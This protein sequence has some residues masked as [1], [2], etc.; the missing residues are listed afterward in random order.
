MH[1][2]PILIELGA[3]L[4]LLAGIA[5]LAHRVGLSPV[6]LYLL[7]GLAFGTGGLVPVELSG[8]F[9]ELSAE[10]GVLLLL[11]LLGAEY[12]GR[13]LVDGLRATAPVA[14][15]DA[16]VNIGI[17]VAAG[18][19]LG[20]TPAGALV[21]GGIT[22]ASSSGIVAKLVD[23][24][25]WYGNREVP[26]I[27]AL[28]VAED[29]LMALYLPVL[30]VLLAGQVGGAPLRITLAVAVVVVVLVLAARYGPPVSDRFAHRSPEVVLLGALGLMLLVAGLVELVDV[31]A[32][33][34][35]FLVGIAIS[36]AF[37]DA[38]K[39]LLAPLRDLFAALFFVVFGLTID[40]A[41][42]TPVLPVALGLAVV[43]G[44]SKYG[45]GIALA[46]REGLGPAATRRTGTILLAR[47]EFSII[48]A[49][50]GTA[51]GLDDRLGP[52]A[53]AYVLALAVVGPV[54]VRLVDRP[55]PARVT[56]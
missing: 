45:V 40:P 49:G 56:T 52:L 4:L 15:L 33:I 25:G 35:A 24:L 21:V 39:S 37:R 19:L 30:G 22:Y 11:L 32:A 36:G 38:A 8:E 29:L 6:P 34:G 3:L 51:A 20:L 28:L 9:L 10:L 55:P 23:D 26:G 46:R 18:V 5:R 48:V 42:L 13:E 50:L 44:A 14:A 1:G 17:G 41:S 7:G 54:L 27:L 53:A 16:V 43:T 31:S 2:G 12:S 47:G